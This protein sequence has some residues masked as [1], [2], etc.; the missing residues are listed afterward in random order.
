MVPHFQAA[1]YYDGHH[2]KLVPQVWS[3][4]Y[5][6]D[7]LN[8]LHKDFISTLWNLAVSSVS[9]A[10]CACICLHKLKFGTEA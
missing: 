9:L 1:V 6:S 4:V 2:C 7:I 5:C 3:H 10:L 8:L